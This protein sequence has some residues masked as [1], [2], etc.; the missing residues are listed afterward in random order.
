MDDPVT[1][2]DPM[3]GPRYGRVCR[4]SLI[5]R[6]ILKIGQIAPACFRG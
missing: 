3:E 5:E 2:R 6:P 4:R 1:L